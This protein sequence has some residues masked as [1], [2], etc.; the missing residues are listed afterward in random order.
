[1]KVITLRIPEDFAQKIEQILQ[2]QLD[3]GKYKSMNTFL[4]EL[5]EKGLEDESTMSGVPG[6]RKMSSL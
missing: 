6:Q 5:L 4:I 3:N 1:M 2:K